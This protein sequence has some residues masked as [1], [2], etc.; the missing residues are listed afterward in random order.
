MKKIAFVLPADLPVPAIK[1]GAIETLVED[2]ILENEI[3]KKFEIVVFS[4]YNQQAKK[5]SIDYKYTKFVYFKFNEVYK[6]LNLPIRII[7]K[8]FKIKIEDLRIIILQLQLKKNNFDKVIIQGLIN[9]LPPIAK[10]ITQDRIIIHLHADIIKPENKKWLDILSNFSGKIVVVSSFIKNRIVENLKIDSD[11]IIVIK[12]CVSENFSNFKDLSFVGK[13]KS[14]FGITN[15]DFVILFI[16]R[17]VEDKG[18]QHLIKAVYKLKDTVNI[19]LIVVGSF[20]SAFGNG[21]T[22]DNFAKETLELADLTDGKVFFTG[23]VKSSL[24]RAYFNLADIIVVP[25]LCN[26]A[27][28]LVPIEGMACGLPIITTTQGGIPE[29]VT[30]ECGILID[31]DEFFVENLKKA[32]LKLYNNKELRIKMGE[33]GKELAKQ[34]TPTVFYNDYLKLIGEN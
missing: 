8:V 10:V 17:I 6:V 16:G 11:Q 21:E 31:V 23:Y 20:G 22:I 29:Y 1:G 24:K 9:H 18:I 5:L 15:D 26:E 12:N 27:A 28:P 2:F 25:S 19:K 7:R 32:I 14:R 34:Y 4:V 13:E 3:K 30:A 33:K